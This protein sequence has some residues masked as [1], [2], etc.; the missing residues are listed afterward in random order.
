MSERFYREPQIA[1]TVAETIRRLGPTAGISLQPYDDHHT[2]EL[3]T[4][5]VNHSGLGI[6]E[7]LEMALAD[8][9]TNPLNKGN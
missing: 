4:V 9:L 6:G 2:G 5:S 3:W 1:T 8:L 7:T